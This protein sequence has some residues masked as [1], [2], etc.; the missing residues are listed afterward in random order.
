M[1]ELREG[2]YRTEAGRFYGTPTE[3]WGFRQS[4]E[5]AA[6]ITMAKRFV[7]ANAALLGVADLRGAL[8]KRA[9]LRSLAATHVILQQRY[10]GVPVHRAFVTVHIAR[11]DRVYLVK[12][13]AIPYALLGGESEFK[14]SD[15]RARRR[16]LR[17]VGL[18]LSQARI[19]RRVERRWFP[20]RERLRPALRVRVL[21][22]TP[23][24]DWIV[25]IDAATARLLS[26]YDNLSRASGRAAVFDPNPVAALGGHADLID[27]EGE[28]VAPP[29]RAYRR[30]TLR[31]LVGNG[32]LDGLRVSTRMTRGR[33]REPSHRF[34]YRSDERGFDEVMA[35]F[36]IDRAVRYVERLGYSGERTI[37]DKPVWVDAHATDED[38]SWFSAETRSLSFGTGGVDDAEDGE[39][40]LHELGHALQDAICPGFGQSREA[41]AMGE[42]FGDY[43]AASFFADKKRPAYRAAV[44]SWDALTFGEHDPPALRRLDEEWTYDDFSSDDGPHDNGE[45][46]S[47]T[48]WD[49]FEALGR[50]VADKVIIESHFQLD[51]F[52]SM[53]RGARAIVDADRNL[54]GGRHGDALRRIFADRRIAPVG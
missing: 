21:R 24:E 14:I 27:D 8:R 10:R 18:P 5:P 29:A 2:E 34:V 41:A 13:R 31:D 38:N 12:N 45:I 6:P 42:G 23:R 36:H 25:Y 40:I 43:F 47:A 17:V 35:Y 9:V 1:G 37:F 30:V 32:R 33:V 53:A 28:P 16:A 26:C 11:G 52:T 22:T 48:L 4:V 7:R 20:L 3:V 49:I 39:T 50:R 44:M 19:V 54:Y 15:E 46:W 51:G